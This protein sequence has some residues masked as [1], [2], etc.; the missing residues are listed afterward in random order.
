G[1]YPNLKGVWGISSVSFPGA[2]DAVKKAGKS[3]QILVTGLATP[4]S[5][6]PAVQD[7]T[8]RSVILWNTEDL[9]Y[10]TIY[11]A[12]ALVKG[13]LKVGA[14]TIKA[15]RL[16]EKKIED[17]K[18]LLGDILVFTKENIDKFDF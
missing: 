6:K 5:M 16:G 8:V 2:A 17:D 10:L 15:G 4:N 11:A 12:K 14:T 9:G 7:G 13:E 18:I 1:A 3:G